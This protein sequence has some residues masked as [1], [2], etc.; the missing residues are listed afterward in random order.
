MTDTNAL[1]QKMEDIGALKQ[2][3]FMRASGRHSDHYVQPGV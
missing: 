2:G 1:R 3:H